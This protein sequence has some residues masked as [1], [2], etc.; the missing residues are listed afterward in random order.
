MK[1]Y[2][3]FCTFSKSA[4]Y[5]KE[6][7]NKIHLTK[8]ELTR[9]FGILF[10]ERFFWFSAIWCFSCIKVE[11]CVSYPEIVISGSKTSPYIY[12]LHL[13][14]S[15]DELFYVFENWKW[16]QSSLKQHFQCI[17]SS[18]PL[19]ALTFTYYDDGWNLPSGPSKK[20]PPFFSLKTLQFGV[21]F[22]T[23]HNLSTL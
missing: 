23:K 2:Y 15:I 14:C 16:I 8:I 4:P 12:C 11:S 10:P 20:Y 3:Y 1:K 19:M 21:G 7:N 18:S 13:K 22:S 9:D 17:F 5:P 6:N